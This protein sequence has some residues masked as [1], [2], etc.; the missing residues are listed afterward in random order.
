[1]TTAARK[2]RGKAPAFKPGR[3]LFQLLLVGGMAVAVPV[4]SVASQ[5]SEGSRPSRAQQDADARTFGDYLAGRFAIVNRD[6][7]A[8]ADYYIRA[9]EG[10]PTNVELVH[11]AFSVAVA[12]G[13]HDDAVKLAKRLGELNEKPTGLTDLRGISKGGPK[14]LSLMKE[15]S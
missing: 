1:M 13:R 7:D 6:T 2:G 12:S 14:T 4:T 10:D 11:Q 15:A 5:P 3:R 8:A 9:V